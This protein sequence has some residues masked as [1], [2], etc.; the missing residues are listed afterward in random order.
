MQITIS[1]FAGMNNLQDKRRL[2]GPKVGKQRAPAECR[3]IVNCDITDSLAALRRGGYSPALAGSPH[4]LWNTPDET[5]AYFVDG[6]FKRLFAGSPNYTAASLRALAAPTFPMSYAPV[7]Y[8]IACSNGID[9]FLIENGFTSD[10]VFSSAEFKEAVMAGHILAYFNGCLYVAVGNALYRTDPYDIQ[11][12]D[13]RD[14]PFV[15]GEMI[16]MVLPCGKNG[17]YVG[18][19]KVHWLSGR[20]PDEFTPSDAYDG[21]VIEG[22]G[23]VLD[24]ALLAEKDFPIQ[25]GDAVIF[26]CADGICVG[27][28]QGQVFNL[29]SDSLSFTAQQRGA[30]LIRKNGEFNQYISWV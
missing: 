16:T 7:N 18:A 26:T 29:T 17:M 1:G 2:G 24:G 19:D 13:E 27:N 5:Q 14:D 30:A 10:F 3:E 25:S 23:L 6:T 15:F 20:G 4:S 8:L 28:D 9:L 21:T 12:L 22:T 11:R